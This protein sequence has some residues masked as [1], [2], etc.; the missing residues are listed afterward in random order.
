MPMVQFICSVLFLLSFPFFTLGQPSSEPQARVQ[1]LTLQADEM[2]RD[3]ERETIE[4]SGRVQIIRGEQHIMCDHAL[5]FLRSKKL[6]L[7][8]NVQVTNQTQTLVGQEILMDYETGTGII[9][10]G[11]VSSGNV[12]FEGQLLQKIGDEEFYVADANYTSC[13]NCPSTWSFSGQ[14]IRAELGGYAYIKNSV[15]RVGGVPVLWLPYLIVPL[16]SDRQSGLLTPTFGSSEDGGAEIA[17]SYFWAIDRSQDLTFTLKN[18]EKRRLMA[19]TNYRYVISEKSKGELDA[20]WIRDRV[21]VKSDGRLQRFRTNP[22][23]FDQFSRWHLHYQHHLELKNGW[24]QRLQLHNASDL[25]FPLDFEKELFQRGLGDSALENRINFSKNTDS[26][27]VDVDSAYYVNLLRADPLSNNEDAIHRIP[28]VNVSRSSQPLGNTPFR[29]NWDLR[30]SSFTRSFQPYDDLSSGTINGQEVTFPTNGTNDPLC[31]NSPNCQ[32]TYDGVFN[33]GT[34]LIRVGQRLDFK[35]QITGYFR[36]KEAL[37][38]VPKLSYRETQY[39]F[40]VGNDQQVA[41]RFL[42]TELTGRLQFSRVY[43]ETLME[44]VRYKHL[45]EPEVTYSSLPWLEQDRSPFF[46]S[47]SFVTPSVGSSTSVSDG[48]IRSGLGLQFDE[49]DRIL[50]RNLITFSLNNRLIQRLWSGESSQYRQV[51]QFRLSQSYNLSE[52]SKSSGIGPWSDLSGLLTVRFNNIETNTNFNYFPKQDVTN[53]KTRTAFINDNGQFYEVGLERTFTIVQGQDVDINKRVEDISFGWGFSTGA[54]NFV[55]QFVYD[56]NYRNSE[57]KKQIKS[58]G[59]LAQL[60]P[61]GECWQI[62]FTQDQQVGGDI[63]T[64]IGFEFSF[65]GVPRPAPPRSTLDQFRN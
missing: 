28:E 35:P 19:L 30:F 11:Y 6:E 56:N 46:P 27:H 45:I 20:A 26:L 51:V 52:E 4:L 37:D 54:A 21:F 62:N 63:R 50:D 10:D 12:T 1:G 34:D 44:S 55:G 47:K 61:P 57:D 23:D 33:E 65:D 53:I 3:H 22:N 24:T 9:K 39:L 13:T 42:K 41:R 16:K 2:L 64:L 36:F 49:T 14:S 18:F 60:K 48:D 58:W 38:I 40:P 17:Q 31:E 15:M 8:G 43:G 29:Y 32:Y 7:R 25:Q 59:Y 5:I